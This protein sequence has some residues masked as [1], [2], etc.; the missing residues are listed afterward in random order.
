V[1]LSPD[2][3]QIAFG[4][5]LPTAAQQY[6]IWLANADGTNQRKLHAFSEPS[7]WSGSGLAWSPDSKLL[8]IS[9][10]SE[11][12]G[13]HMTIGGVAV[14]DGAFKVLTSQRWFDVGRIAWYADGSGM[15]VVAVSNVAQSFQVWEVS[16]PGG[17]TRRITNDLHSYGS[18]SLTLTADSQ[19]LVALQEEISANIWI[20]PEGDTSRARALTS[21]KSAQDHGPVFTPDGRIVFASNAS[22]KPGLWIMNA[23]G[24][25]QKAL[26][27]EAYESWSP[28]VS[29]DGHYIF[30]TSLRSGTQQVWRMDIDGSSPKQM[31]NQTGVGYFAVTPD[32]KWIIYNLWTPGVWKVSV[33]GGT[34][35]K[36]LDAAARGAE[37]SPDGKLLAYDIEDPQTKRTQI[38]ITNF[39][40]LTQVKT[41]NRPVTAEGWRWAPDSRAIIYRDRKG[42]ISN[43]VRQP[44]DGA[45]PT[46]ITDFKSEAI[47]YFSYSLDGKQLVMSR[48]SVT[49]DA[50][51]I[52]DEK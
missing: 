5:Y 50:V 8:A 21:R 38:V 1:A 46:Q 9:Y 49:R 3:R 12:G 26:T 39:P 14:A 35:E 51:L 27:D 28:M 10:G 24:S 29:P 31:T 48:G 36:I 25:E 47:R 18:F 7:Y 43:L 44:V 34:P 15:A 30:F 42:D 52:T 33:D 16:Y 37:V 2:G 40:D 6:E 19:T 4:R 32:A 11:E 20:V 22:G 17:A 13:E 45:S 23:D 41:L